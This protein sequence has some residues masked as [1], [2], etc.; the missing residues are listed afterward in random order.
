YKVALHPPKF[1]P[2]PSP[3]VARLAAP[4]LS[5]CARRPVCQ[6]LL[7]KAAHPRLS[8]RLHQPGPEN[9]TT[10]PVPVFRRPAVARRRTA[11][12]HT[13]GVTPP[14]PPVAGGPAWLLPL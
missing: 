6:I 13:P 11:R 3:G 10:W 7:S 4:A 2:R 5:T 8:N 9:R 12:E 1:S 14:E